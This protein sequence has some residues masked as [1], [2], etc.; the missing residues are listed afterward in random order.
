MALRV[1]SVQFHHHPINGFDQF[2]GQVRRDVL[3]SKDFG[4]KLVCFPEYMTG[5]L[6]SIP[7]ADPQSLE[8]WDRWTTPYL[9]L[10]SDLA[11][12]HGMHILGGT[13]LVRDG[14]RWYN[15]AHLFTP[16]G[17]V[18]TQRKLHMT[19]FE[20]SPWNLGSGEKV[21]VFET[22]LGRVAILV[23]Y[24]I[25]FPEATRVAADAGAD[26][27]LCPSAT[28]DRAGFWR[29]RYS[30]FAR[31]IENQVFVVHSALV[32]GLPDVRGLEQSYGRSGLISPCDVPF[33]RDGVIADGEWNQDLVVTGL[34]QPELLAEVRAAG[35]VTPRLSRR[36][37]YQT[38][39]VTTR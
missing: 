9:E 29:V 25:E 1:S 32:G 18:F 19:P 10:F 33:A 30:C 2:A 14:D 5:S 13:H 24:D 27:I 4:S 28:D 22:D 8:A 39:S 21:R 35:S 17:S 11:K 38:E 20:V 31:A 23:C 3:L 16:T 34:I 36:E 37:A 12:Q 6:L 7:G 26:I 15:T